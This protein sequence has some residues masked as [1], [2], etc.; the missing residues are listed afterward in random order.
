MCGDLSAPGSTQLT[1]QLLQISHIKDDG[2]VV[3]SPREGAYRVGSKH[4]A[5][6]LAHSPFDGTLLLSLQ[7]SVL[8]QRFM[9]V[10]ELKVGEVIKVR[11]AGVRGGGARTHTNVS[12][13]LS[14]HDQTPHRQGHV[15][16][17]AR[18][19]RWHGLAITLRGYPIEKSGEEVQGGKHGQVQSELRRCAWHCHTA[20]IPP[21]HPLQILS[22]DAEKNRILLTLKKSLVD[23]KL[24]IP[25]SI[26]DVT[27]DM[28]TPGTIAKVLDKALLVEVFGG[29]RVFVPISEASDGY[30]TDLSEHFFAG[31]PV[32]VRVTSIAREQGRLYGSLRQALPGYVAVEAIEIGHIVEGIVTA[33]HKEQIVLNLEPSQSKALLSMGNEANH[34]SVAL[35]DL[36]ASLKIGEKLT[37]L[38][39]LAKSNDT[40]LFIV[41]NKPKSGAS[42]PVA[43][44]RLTL[45]SIQP[46][47]ILP[48]RIISSNP[49]GA[50]LQ[51][52]RNVKGRLHRTDMV[53]DFEKQP[54]QHEVG[55]VVKCYVVKVDLATSQMDLST[56]PSRV[57]T[58][59]SSEASTIKDR[60][61]DA[62]TSLKEGDRV[63]GF[64]K[65]IGSAGLFVTLGRSVTAR[66]QIKEMFDD[67]GG[68]G[69][70]GGGILADRC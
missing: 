18:E 25:T 44:P 55:E 63:R 42:K 36:R 58:P 24:P 53:D 30:V 32:N 64:V 37:D 51:V 11:V 14:G 17:L 10:S 48:A 70:D 50:F 22:I 5:R 16:Q 60:E 1:N 41:G 45:S 56:R 29:L 54:P 40:G 46:G 19:R 69:P 61:V 9:L 39:V 13:F 47:Q 2:Q 3:L 21:P 7:K 38:V 28:I 26:D 20:E 59:G 27:L 49:Q 62:A 35:D 66:V 15:C 34:R 57:N 68:A 33:V 43:L 31:K 65:S 6:V 67:V 12:S 52:A 23:S 8:E 4:R